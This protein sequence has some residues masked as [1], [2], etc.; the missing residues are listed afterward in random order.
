MK[1][2]QFVKITQIPCYIQ[3]FAVNKINFYGKLGFYLST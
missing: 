1:N 3:G 2:Y